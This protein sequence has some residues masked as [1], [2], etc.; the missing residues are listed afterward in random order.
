MFVIL[1]NKTKSLNMICLLTVYIISVIGVMLSISF[2]YL[3]FGRE[4]FEYNMIDSMSFDKETVEEKENYLFFCLILMVVLPILNTVIF[5]R[6]LNI[7]VN[8]FF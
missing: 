4:T 6:V 7:I 5:F 1:Q 3:F 2:L 8:K